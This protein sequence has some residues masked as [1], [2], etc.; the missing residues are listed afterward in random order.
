[1]SNSN[2]IISRELRA[3]S[4]SM[5]HAEACRQQ[6]AQRP[7]PCLQDAPESSAGEGEVEK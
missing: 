5:L 2:G 7:A 6:E 4:R 3:I 1:M